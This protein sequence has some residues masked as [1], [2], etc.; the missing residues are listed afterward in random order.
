MGPRLR[1]DDSRGTMAKRAFPFAAARLA[2]PV[3]VSLAR[4]ARGLAAGDIRQPRPAPARR[5]HRPRPARHPLHGG[6]DRDVRGLQRAGEM[7]GGQLFVRRGAVLPRP[8]LAG[9]LRRADPA[10]HRPHRVP[11]RAP[12]RTHRPQRNA[13]GGAEPDHHRLLADAARRRHRHQFHLAAVCHAVCRGLA[14]GK[15]RPRARLRA[16]RRIS[17]RAAGGGARRR[18]FPHR[19]AVRARQCRAV[20]QRHRRGARHDHHRVRRKP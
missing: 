17:R 14:Q 18:Q 4:S 9:G 3:L 8:R 19:R 6:R 1:G 5:A 7:A 13:G 12:A 2:P 11:H 16:H 15:S 20:R 10:A